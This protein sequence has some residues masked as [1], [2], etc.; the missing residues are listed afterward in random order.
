MSLPYE[1]V[2]HIFSTVSETTPQIEREKTLNIRLVCTLFNTSIV[3]MLRSKKNALSESPNTKDPFSLLADRV[4]HY[5]FHQALKNTQPF[6]SNFKL[7][8]TNEKEAVQLP[9]NNNLLLKEA[10]QLPENN[11]LLLEDS[12]YTSCL[13]DLDKKVIIK[14]FEHPSEAPGYEN[15]TYPDLNFFDWEWK[16]VGDK[17]CQICPS[18]KALIVFAQKENVFHTI[19]YASSEDIFHS[20][21]PLKDDRIALVNKIAGTAALVCL[22]N[23][24]IL[25]QEMAIVLRGMI[26]V[27]LIRV[28]P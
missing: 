17:F 5:H 15:L 27:N 23:N 19:P 7:K 8:S 26:K 1:L 12:C 14:Q 22:K 16:Q 21:I 28:C 4:W 2:E 13:W 20:A 25:W 11:N 24:K 10:V 18:K 6:I 3:N 9:E